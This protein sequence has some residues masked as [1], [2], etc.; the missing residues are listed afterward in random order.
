L[1]IY[2]GIYQNVLDYHPI[3]RAENGQEAMT[4]EL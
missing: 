3:A 1:Q 2:D 4:S